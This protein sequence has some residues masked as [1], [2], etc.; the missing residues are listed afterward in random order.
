MRDIRGEEVTVRDKLLHVFTVVLKNL[1]PP[2]IRLFFTKIQCMCACGCHYLVKVVTCTCI[3]HAIEFVCSFNVK[4][5]P[6]KCYIYT[7][8]KLTL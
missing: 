5:L 3:Q 7:I 8:I 6:L 2:I 1:V 4:Y